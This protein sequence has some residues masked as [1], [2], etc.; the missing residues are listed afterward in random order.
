[1][2]KATI[3][4]W[5]RHTGAKCGIRYAEINADKPFAYT[6][7]L[8]ITGENEDDSD[9]VINEALDRAWNHEGKVT[10]VCDV[11]EDGDLTATPSRI[12]ILQD[13]DRERNVWEEAARMR[14]A[15]DL[16]GAY[17]SGGLVADDVS[18]D[19]HAMIM[20]ARSAQRGG[21]IDAMKAMTQ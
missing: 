6:A 4:G 5:L 8:I 20:I 2:T 7:Q 13:D 18:R 12:T 3:T 15:V 10:I 11:D 9:D 16:I 19:R 21:S 17:P 14:A 1:M